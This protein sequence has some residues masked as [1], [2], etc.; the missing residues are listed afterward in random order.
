MLAIARKTAIREQ[1]QEHKS[2]RIADLA[3]QLNV[4]KET[5]R[6]DLKEMEE[7][8]ELIRT[9]GG[10]YILDGVQN[11]LDPHLRKVIKVPE[12]EIIAQ[13][14]S[15]LI[16]AGDYIFL[17]GS[18]TCWSIARML[19]GRKITVLT[20]SLEI[21]NI[22]ADSGTVKLHVIGGKFSSDYMDFVGVGT[23]RALENYYVDKA[24]ISCRSV[25]LEY[26]ITDTND[27]RAKLHQTALA[28]AN[29]KYLVFDHS[30]INN[31]SFSFIAPLTDVDGVI[32]DCTL[33][34]EWQEYL[35][36][37]QIDIY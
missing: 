4:T 21:A 27:D 1:L 3:T 36:E 13:K 31:V 35:A 32:T 34:T 8:N 28:H 12:K 15:S 16:L 7:N 29:Q 19:T 6:R 14:C 30:K 23:I 37:H 20:S 18:T 17:D 33:P 9:H 26:G 10:A 11:D 22:L 25:D 24:F 5:I 2:V